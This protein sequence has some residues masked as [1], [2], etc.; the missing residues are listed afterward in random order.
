MTSG[1]S[2][3]GMGRMASLP[4]IASL[5]LRRAASSELRVTWTWGLS[6]PYWLSRAWYWIS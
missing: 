4:A 3:W 6:G 1:T 2:L 5:H